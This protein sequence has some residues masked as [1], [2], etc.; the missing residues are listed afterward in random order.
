MTLNRHHSRMAALLAQASARA[1]SRV[2]AQLQQAQA[3]FNMQYL[4]LQS[5]LQHENRQYTAISNVLKTKHD[6]VKNSISN[7]R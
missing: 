5:R 4:Q 7:V 1:E 6:T 3:D 2:I